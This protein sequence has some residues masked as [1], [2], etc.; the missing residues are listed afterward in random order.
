MNES[1]R[2]D[3]AES[4][5]RYSNGPSS[6][7][8]RKNVIYLW[9]NRLVAMAF[10][11]VT[12]PIIVNGM[13]AELV[14]VWFYA[15]Q[16][17]MQ[18]AVLDMGITNGLTRIMASSSVTVDERK[19]IFTTATYFLAFVA[20]VILMI[21]PFLSE[22]LVADIGGLSP[23]AYQQGAKLVNLA[24]MTTAVILLL[25]PGYS[26]LMG[27]HRFDLV[28]WVEAVGLALKFFLIV[29]IFKFLE[30]TLAKLGVAVYS[31]Q[32]VAAFCTFAIGLKIYGLRVRELSFRWFSVPR[33]KKLMSISLAMT[34]ISLGSVIL[35]Q[36]STVTSA[37]VFGV[38]AIAPITLS[39]LVFVSI[40]PFFQVFATVIAP[41]AAGVSGAKE[42]ELLKH[43]LITSSKYIM[44]FCLSCAVF[45][46][47]NGERLLELWLSGRNIGA[48]E[49][50]L[51]NSMLVWLL[52]GYAVGVTAFIGK[53]VL[54]SVEGHWLVAIIEISTAIVGLSMAFGLAVYLDFGLVGFAIGSASIYMFRGCLIYPFFLARFF[55]T[56]SWV[57]VNSVASKTLLATGVSF[58][59]ADNLNFEI[60][61][62][63]FKP[64]GFDLAYLVFGVCQVLFFWFVIIE[65]KH[66]TN[67]RRL[68]VS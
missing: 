51:I 52:V 14:A 23:D 19:R 11:L 53:S 28:Q 47:M 25:R 44:F 50:F 22:L 9:L 59:I 66:R 61:G 56:S 65:P 2:T 4:E 45:F 62:T 35:N 46:F 68:V 15:T 42:V 5:K 18:F 63:V 67:I 33:L 17:A 3:S 48:K 29:L 31:I 6:S 12:T 7:Q 38:D 36:G 37:H 60:A 41:I 1:N 13:S 54:S 58:L 49:V 34:A 57:L 30:P 40:T 43:D 16:I 55:K 24:L 10:P 21:A 8:T 64:Y 26:L 39:L 20:S 32:L 27:K